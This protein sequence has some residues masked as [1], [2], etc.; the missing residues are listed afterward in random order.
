MVDKGRKIN[1]CGSQFSARA[2]RTRPSEPAGT[3][4]VGIIE[5]FQPR[6]VDL[7]NLVFL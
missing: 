6:Y 5:G 2:L 1:W 4:S 3:V 7:I